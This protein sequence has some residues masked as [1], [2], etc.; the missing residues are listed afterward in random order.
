MDNNPET[1]PAMFQF[2][3]K[4]GTDL[5]ISGNMQGAGQYMPLQ[6]IQQISGSS[7]SETVKKRLTAGVADNRASVSGILTAKA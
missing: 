3:R 1:L 5:P 2:A 4:T 6:H 7:D